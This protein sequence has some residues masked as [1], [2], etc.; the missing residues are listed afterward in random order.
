MCNTEL[1][2]IFTNL[3]INWR[4][5]VLKDAYQTAFYTSM[6]CLWWFLNSKLLFR[7]TPPF[8]MLIFNLLL[9]TKETYLNCLNTMLFALLVM[10]LTTKQ[11]LFLHLMSFTT[12]GEE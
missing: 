5:L 2:I 11:V 12:L 8:I 10:V 4:L 9:A 7:R 3:L 6:G 1:I